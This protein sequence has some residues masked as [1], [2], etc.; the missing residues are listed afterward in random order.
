MNLNN[1]ALYDTC[2]VE[3]DAATVGAIFVALVTIT[4]GSQQTCSVGALRFSWGTVGS[5]WVY[6][7]TKEALAIAHAIP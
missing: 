1:V 5:A 6:G 3:E 4:W 2:N 7:T